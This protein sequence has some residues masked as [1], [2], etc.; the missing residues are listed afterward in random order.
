VTYGQPVDG[1]GL[2]E[3]AEWLVDSVGSDAVPLPGGLPGVA[4]W[5]H[6]LLALPEACDAAGQPTFVSLSVTSTDSFTEHRELSETEGEAGGVEAVGEMLVAA[7]QRGMERAGCAPADPLEVSAAWPGLPEDGE[8]LFDG[9]QAPCRIPGLRFSAL[10][11]DDL[12]LDPAY[13]VGTVGD[14]LQSCSLSHVSDFVAPDVT[15]L[16]VA[17]PWLRAVFG[18]GVTGGGPLPDGWRGSG[19]VDE[20]LSVVR[21]ECGEEPVLFVMRADAYAPVFGSDSVE[22]FAAFANAAAHRVGCA[23]VAQGS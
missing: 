16:M 6:G 13:Q 22:T 2:A 10:D 1:L 23:R 9:D 5:R 18:D 3:R 4:G 14:T 15:L 17:E 7:A 11:N 8:T 20:S 19:L 12:T 21:A